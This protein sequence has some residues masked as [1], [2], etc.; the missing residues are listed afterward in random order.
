MVHST[1]ITTDFCQL[2]SNDCDHARIG[3]ISVQSLKKTARRFKI[4]NIRVRK[5]D[6]V[7]YTKPF[8]S[9]NNVPMG[10]RIY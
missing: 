2:P 7:L 8:R 10:H 9:N 3:N 4:R 1:D 5:S 6:D